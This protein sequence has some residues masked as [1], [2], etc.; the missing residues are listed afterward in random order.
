MPTANPML[1]DANYDN[2]II[3][4]TK[5]IGDAEQI[6]P[7]KETAK[8]YTYCFMGIRLTEEKVAELK[9]AM[10]PNS[11]FYLEIKFRDIVNSEVVGDIHFVHQTFESTVLDSPDNPLTLLM[12]GYYSLPT[13]EPVTSVRI[14]GA[15]IFY[16]DALP[17]E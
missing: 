6:I 15:K 14:T 9:A 13:D 17:A 3:N 4:H 10:K 8:N 11:K 2:F 7:D 12:D 1:F 16:V 5:P